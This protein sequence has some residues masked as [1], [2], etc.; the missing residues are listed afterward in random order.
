MESGIYWG[1]TCVLVLQFLK[2]IL[3]VPNWP[4]TA[5]TCG[6]AARWPWGMIVGRGGTT[7]V[8]DLSQ[9][10][11]WL[12]LLGRSAHSKNAEILVLRREALRVEGGARP[13]RRA[14]AAAWQELSAVRLGD[15]GEDGKQR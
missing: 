9:V 12:G 10:V 2:V 15:A 13:S 3:W 7:A 5:V 11:A 14:I 4:S 6:I 1:M 8:S